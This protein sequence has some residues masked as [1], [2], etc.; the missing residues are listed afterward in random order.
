MALLSRG[1]VLGTTL[2]EIFLNFLT[3]KKVWSIAYQSLLVTLSYVLQSSTIYLFPRC[4]L[5]Q[6]HV[7]YSNVFVGIISLVY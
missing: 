7:I 3:F 2:A 1:V 5:L 4:F 6:L